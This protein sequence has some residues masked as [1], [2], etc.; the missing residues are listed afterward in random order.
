MRDLAVIIVST[1]EAHW[2]TACLHSIFGHAGDAGLDVVVVDN[3]STDGTS[4]LVERDFPGARVVRS[5]NHGFGHANNRGLLTC[6][7]RYVLFINPDTEVKEGRFDDLVRRMDSRPTVG[8]IGV[9]QVGPEGKLHPTMRRFPNALRAVGDAFA[10]ER[11]PDPISR[12]GE[13]CVDMSAYDQEQPCDWTSGSFMLVRR[14]ALLSAGTLDERFFIYSEEPDLCVRMKRA[15]WEIRHVPWMTIVHHAGKAGHK[16]GIVVQDAYSRLQYARKHFGRLHRGAYMSAVVGRHA[17]RAMLGGRDEEERAARRVTARAA[18]WTVLGR[19][20]PP[21]GR[22]P[23]TA[24]A[25]GATNAIPAGGVSA[26][27]CD[28]RQPGM[29]VADQVRDGGRSA[30]PG[31]TVP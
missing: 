24:L 9:R 21:H 25:A 22:A 23:A 26:S 1:N 10:V 8:L 7:A 5:A 20:E 3:E 6:D 29:D 12:L 4:A 31:V 13:R 15:G 30:L 2:L 16:P 17:L 19:L 27:S 28:A 11:L 18:M 14:E